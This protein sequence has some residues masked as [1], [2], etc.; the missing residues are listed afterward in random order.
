MFLTIP[1]H[2]LFGVS[3]RDF[4]KRQRHEGEKTLRNLK[5][6]DS[7]QKAIQVTSS[8]RGKRSNWWSNCAAR[9]PCKRIVFQTCE[10]GAGRFRVQKLDKLR[11]RCLRIVKTRTLK[12]LSVHGVIKGQD[13]KKGS[14]EPL[15]ADQQCSHYFL[16][17]VKWFPSRAVFEIA[18]WNCRTESKQ[19]L[20]RFAY[21][22]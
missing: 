4:F 13:R 12:S 10:L 6:F 15:R 17:M 8:V 2:T 14:Q 9:G 7:M 21:S 20:L 11:K 22:I 3:C 5:N 18:R 1:A 19:L 16:S